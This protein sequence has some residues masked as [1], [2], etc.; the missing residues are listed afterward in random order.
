M[1]LEEIITRD[2]DL[3]FE[4]DVSVKVRL[5]DDNGIELNTLEFSEGE[6]EDMSLG[7]NMKDAYKVAE[8][9]RYAYKLGQTG[10]KLEFTYEEVKEE[11]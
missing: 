10:N 4:R 6:P 5:L 9:V 11:E 1:K 8:L 3:G 7:R 2:N